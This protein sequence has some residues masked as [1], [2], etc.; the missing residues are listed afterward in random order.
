MTRSI[1]KK[2]FDKCS[3]YRMSKK[4]KNTHKCTW[5]GCVSAKNIYYPA[6]IFKLIGFFKTTNILPK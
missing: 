2:Y 4:E 6:G 1:A 5:N 3:I